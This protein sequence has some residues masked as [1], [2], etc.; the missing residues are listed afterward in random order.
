[1]AISVKSIRIHVHMNPA[2]VINTLTN[3]LNFKIPAYV[4][5]SGAIVMASVYKYLV[6]LLP[7]I[8]DQGLKERDEN[9]R[10]KK[11]LVQQMSDIM[12]EAEELGWYEPPLNIN[13]FNLL[14]H[15]L[16]KY[17][18]R[19]GSELKLNYVDSWIFVSSFSVN[20]RSKL[21]NEEKEILKDSLQHLRDLNLRFH[22]YAFPLGKKNDLSQYFWD[23]FYELKFVLKKKLRRRRREMVWD[24]HVAS[25]V[26]I[27]KQMDKLPY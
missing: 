12:L 21:D 14:C 5:A 6:P 16:K 24:S 13:K 25:I 22:K 26:N 8:F 17:N 23:K 19:L 1:M 4:V 18:S 20:S 27:V 11:E 7:K 15:R 10:D 3:S 9:K 2:D